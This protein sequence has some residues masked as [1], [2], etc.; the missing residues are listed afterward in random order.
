MVDH[1]VQQFGIKEDKDI[2]SNARALRK[3]RTACEKAKRVLSTVSKTTIEIDSLYDGVDFC[4]AI[5]RDEFDEINSDLFEMCMETIEDC[6]EEAKIDKG[7]IDDIIPVGGSTRIPK[8]QQ[9]LQEFFNGKELYK[10]INPDETV[11][12]GATIQAA[13]LT[14]GKEV[15]RDKVNHG[16]K[17]HD[18]TPLS[19]GLETA[20]GDISVLIPRNS[21]IPTK[22]E[23]IFTTNSNDQTSIS[24]QLRA[25]E[26]G[27]FLGKYDLIDLPFCSRGIPK[28]HVSFSINIDGILSVEAFDMTRGNKRDIHCKEISSCGGG[29]SKEEIEKLMH[30][31]EKYEV[32]DEENLKRMEAKNSLEDY[33]YRVRELARNARVAGKL[34][35]TEKRK[36][37]RSVEQAIDWLDN[38]Q[39]QFAKASEFEEKLLELKQ[40]CDPL[41]QKS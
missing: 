6:L 26:S 8:I 39:V 24:I 5:S 34:Y 33:A 27:C 35:F 2:S 13:I 1:F 36:I 38:E 22:K 37:E 23:H 30:E 40:V 18:V 9:Q 28:V 16:L 12:H 17:V 29:L 11:A 15:L 31:L 25:C 14:G 41:V 10:S 7:M 19:L 21:P 3:L 4:S 32:D 20:G